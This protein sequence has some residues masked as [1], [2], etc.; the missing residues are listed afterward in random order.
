MTTGQDEPPTGFV[1]VRQDD[2][3][4]R[5]EVE[6]FSNRATAEAR[7][8]ELAST[9]YRHKQ[10]Y[11]VEETDEARERPGRGSSPRSPG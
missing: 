5:F 7:L 3:G 4:H 10:S 8:A 11:W 9:P 6:R 1:L 2:N